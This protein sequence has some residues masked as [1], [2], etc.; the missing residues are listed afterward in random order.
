MTHIL[1]YEEDKQTK[2]LELSSTEE[3]LNYLYLAQLVFKNVK[4]LQFR[5]RTS[6]FHS[7]ESGALPGWATTLILS[8]IC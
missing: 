8:A 6:D 2:T 4:A 5:S 3:L 7:E 1:Q